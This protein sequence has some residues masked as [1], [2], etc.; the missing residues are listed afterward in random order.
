MEG[1][2]AKKHWRRR[3]AVRRQRVARETNLNPNPERGKRERERERD[4][5]KRPFSPP[6]KHI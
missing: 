1:R 3:R 4:L 2:I 5:K 6:R